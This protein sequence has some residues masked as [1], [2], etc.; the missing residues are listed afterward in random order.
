[1]T[2]ARSG[3]AR[4]GLRLSRSRKMPTTAAGG[5]SSSSSGTARAARGRRR[6]GRRR[7]GRRRPG[8]RRPGRAQGAVAT[9]EPHAGPPPAPWH[10]RPWRARHWRNARGRRRLAR[11]KNDPRQSRR[12]YPRLAVRGARRRVASHGRAARSSRAAMR[13]AAPAAPRPALAP[14]LASRRLRAGARHP[15]GRRVRRSVLAAGFNRYGTREDGPT[16]GSF[17]ETYGLDLG[18]GTIARETLTFPRDSAAVALEVA[19]PSA[20]SSRTSATGGAPRWRSSRGPTPPPRR[21]GRRRPEAHVRGAAG[22]STVE[23]GKFQVEP[24]LG[25]R[26]KG[27]NRRACFCA[28]GQS[29]AATMDAV[30]SNGE[31]VDGDVARDGAAPRETEYAVNRDERIVRTETR[32]FGRSASAVSVQGPLS[33]KMVTYKPFETYAWSMYNL[34]RAL[35]SARPPNSRVLRERQLKQRAEGAPGRATRTRSGDSGGVLALRVRGLAHHERRRFMFAKKSTSRSSYRYLVC[36]YTTRPSRGAPTFSGRTASRPRHSPP[37]PP[38]DV[39]SRVVI[40]ARARFCLAIFAIGTEAR[41][42]VRERGDAGGV[43]QR[44]LPTMRSHGTSSSR[45]P[46]PSRRRVLTRSCVGGGTLRGSYP[47]DAGG[48]LCTRSSRT[49]PR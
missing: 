47:L 12:L 21:G 40:S 14:R 6:P 36:A 33:T 26:K 5:G 23:V 46:R 15:S 49:P 45:D 13:V 39:S 25:M 48:R 41:D 43:V 3:L 2:A 44:S 18:G 7:P 29:F 17:M 20:S 11:D 24:S 34:R 37:P 31:D 8:R 22:K 9:R 32:V 30:V 35:P 42:D 10:R 4:P 1:M 28:D 16:P 27:A 38:R 19:R